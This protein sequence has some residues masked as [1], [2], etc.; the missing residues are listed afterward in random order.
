MVPLPAYLRSLWERR[1][2]MLAL[3]RSENRKLRSNAALGAVWSVLDPLLQAFIYFML[4]SVIRGGSRAMEFLPV[5]IG[6][7]LLFRLALA[8]MTEGG[9]SLKQSKSLVLNSTF[10]RA[11]FPVTTVFKGVLTMP[12]AIAVWL[13]FQLALGASLSWG[14]LLLPVLFAFQ[15]VSMVGMSLLVCTVVVYFKDAENAVQYLARMMFF[16]TPVIY[17]VSLLSDSL[18]A[19]L[20]WQPYFALF[21]SYQEIFNGGAPSL[22]QVTQIVLWAVVLLVIGLRVFRRHEHEFAIRL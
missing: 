15:V 17:P 20:S 4:Y 19:V 2:F 13:A 21:A 9:K 11:L 12:P 18:R 10:P 8:A 6:G 7:I 3:A 5:V 1:H 22:W 16:V 14:V